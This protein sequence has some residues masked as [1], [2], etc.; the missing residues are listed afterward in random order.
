MPFSCI[1][2]E[3]AREKK[4]QQKPRRQQN[5]QHSITSLNNA[6][7]LFLFLI[8]FYSVKCYYPFPHRPSL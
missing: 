4:T 6:I 1:L 3:H 2:S 7:H 5:M 8:P